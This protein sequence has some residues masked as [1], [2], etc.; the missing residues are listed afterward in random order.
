ME[1]RFPDARSR[2]SD[3]VGRTRRLGVRNR[4]E[5]NDRTQSGMMGSIVQLD[6]GEDVVLENEIAVRAA[7]AE[8]LETLVDFNLKMADETEG[9]QLDPGTLRAGIVAV[10]PDGPA[11]AVPTGRYLVAVINRQVVGALMHT[12]E[13]SDWRN[14]VVW[15]LQSVYVEPGFRR[16]GVFRSLYEVLR[17]EALA[18]AT[19]V[20]LRLY[21]E[22]ENEVAQATYR[23]LGMAQSGYVVMEEMLPDAD[24]AGDSMG[25]DTG[26]FH[27]V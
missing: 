6:R 13:W 9:K 15:W 21:V 12:W 5:L 3:G 23:G 7:R 16:R 4:Y 18:D 24:R 10:L 11:V 26:E 2:E 14:G 22:H 17:D 25:P 1:D 20:G 8:D 19:V 27:P